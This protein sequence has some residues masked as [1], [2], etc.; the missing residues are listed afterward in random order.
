MHV[1]PARKPAM[2]ES[3]PLVCLVETREDGHHPMYAGVYAQAL[4]DLG[5]DV[6]LVAPAPLLEVM[7]S[8]ATSPGCGDSA[9][10]TGGFTRLAWELPLRPGEG[11]RRCEVV[12]ARLWESLAEVLDRCPRVPRYPDFLLLLYFDDFL[13]EILPQRTVDALIRCPFAG[14]LFKPPPRKPRTLRDAAKRLVRVGRRYTM[15]RSPRCVAVL[16]L[17]ASESVHL[18]KGVRP[19]IVEV[20]EV[21]VAGLPTTESK[22]VSDIRRRAA[23][24]SIFSLVGSVDDRKGLAAFLRAAENAPADEWLFVL[25][26]R[27]EW[28]WINGDSQDRIARLASGT[29][30]R[31]VLIDQWLEDEV[32][33]AVVASS[34]L[35][36]VYYPGWRY[37][38]NMFCKT[39]S[40][41]V[42]ALGSTEGYVGR[43]LRHYDLGLTVSSFDDYVATFVPGAAARVAT[44]AA[45]QAFHE[46][47]RRYLA[48]N[49]PTALGQALAGLLGSKLVRCVDAAAPGGRTRT[50]EPRRQG[51]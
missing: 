26:G 13:A 46:G 10:A 3:R 7:P 45:S 16:L 32:L 41:G 18:Q 36:H 43:M 34:Q 8:V 14:L 2:D 31:L 6:L 23:G 30:P 42:P 4:V 51:P 22:V 35:L 17:D 27:V 38:T 9:R 25:A 39:A 37:S 5:Y 1:D 47:C 29:S 11:G 20:P 48:S 15:L 12:A 49:N 21:S 24:R 50:P 44:L 19:R 28:R 33:N 40:L